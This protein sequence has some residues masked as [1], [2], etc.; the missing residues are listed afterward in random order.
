MYFLT[1]IFCLFQGHGK[2]KITDLGGAIKKESAVFWLSRTANG[3]YLRNYDVIITNERSQPICMVSL[4][5]NG[6]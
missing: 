3:F 6:Q 4:L 2:G 1:L 5:K